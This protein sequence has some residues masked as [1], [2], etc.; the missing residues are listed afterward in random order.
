MYFS[1]GSDHILD[2]DLW[3]NERDRYS[4]QKIREMLR[5]MPDKTRV[6]YDMRGEITAFYVK[7]EELERLDDG[8]HNKGYV[9][10]R[11]NNRLI[12]GDGLHMDVPR[13]T[14]DVAFKVRIRCCDGQ[15]GNVEKGE[16]GEALTNFMFLSSVSNPYKAYGGS[17]MEKMERKH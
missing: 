17:D 7:W 9:L 16:I 3:V 6:E 4:D 14:D 8:E 15:L 11:M 13:V 2:I 10:D 5:T 1:L 12:F